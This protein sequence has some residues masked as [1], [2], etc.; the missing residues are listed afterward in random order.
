MDFSCINV[1]RGITYCLHSLLLHFPD[2]IGSGKEKM[3][4]FFSKVQE[5]LSSENNF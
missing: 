4:G 1:E 3:L 5:E 2:C